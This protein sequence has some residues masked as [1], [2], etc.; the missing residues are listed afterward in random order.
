ML[1]QPPLCHAFDTVILRFWKEGRSERG[2]KEGMGPPPD[3]LPQQLTPPV[4][5][6]VAF[7]KAKED[8]KQMINF[9]GL[10][11]R[12]V[13]IFLIT[14]HWTDPFYFNLLSFHSLLAFFASFSEAKSHW[15]VKKIFENA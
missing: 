9:Q 1:T 14:A 2:R 10:L 15:R 7:V 5:D 12:S 11:Y 8:F 3:L 13:Y 4:A 6:T